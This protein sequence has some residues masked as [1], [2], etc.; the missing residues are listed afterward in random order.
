MIGTLLLPAALREQ[1]EQEARA[2]FPRE[3]C[4]LIEGEVRS[5]TLSPSKGQSPPVRRRFS[6]G[7][8]KGLTP[9]KCEPGD[10]AGEGSN[11]EI[12]ALHPMP[13]IA[14]KS[15]RFEIDPSAH[16]ALLRGLRE[17]GRDIIGCYHS[18]PNGRP[19][20]SPRDIEGAGETDFLW[21]IAALEHERAAP[22]FGCFI[23][24]GADFTP[25]SIGTD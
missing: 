17:T 5:L 4:G 23:W 10:L 7:G 2:A 8:S 11:V 6:G 18:H 24:N 21:L 1:L 15:D 22:Q 12:A 13:N 16:I 20:P 25:V 9:P 3:C 14:H 19:E